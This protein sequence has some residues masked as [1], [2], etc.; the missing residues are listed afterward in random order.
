MPFGAAG[1]LS[2]DD[3]YAIVAYLLYSNDMVDDDFVLTNETFLEIEM[4]NADGFVLDDREE[5]EYAVWRAEPCMSDCKDSVEITMRASVV[6]VT[7]DT[8]GDDMA[9]DA[10]THDDAMV[11]EESVSGDTTTASIDPA[12]IEAGAGVFRQCSSCHEVGEGASNRV[13]PQLNGLLG[14]T[15]GAVDGFRY[16]NTFKASAEASE[17]WGDE[18]LRAFLADP[19]GTMSGTKMAFRGISD[20]EDMDAIMAYLESLGAE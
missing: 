16:S 4:E 20:P 8:G 2:A 1:T 15:I 18:N 10:E 3:T 13:G 5:R 17:I 14:R 19:R 7:P 9:M 6:D 12:L 11:V